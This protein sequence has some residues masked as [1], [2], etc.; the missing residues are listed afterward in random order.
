MNNFAHNQEPIR[1]IDHI[2]QR[3]DA[4]TYIQILIEADGTIVNVNKAARKLMGG[5]E[6]EGKNCFDLIPMNDDMKLLR[7][8]YL[9]EASELD[10]PLVLQDDNNGKHYRH[11]I[12]PIK[13]MEENTTHF[14]VL[15]RIIGSTNKK[16]LQTM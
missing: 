2:V 15:S 12:H 5:G 9:D 6:V 4:S 7:H 8:E 13:D 11:F 10:V 16:D 14:M 3:R 1:E